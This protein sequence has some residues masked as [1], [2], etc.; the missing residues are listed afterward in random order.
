LLPIAELAKLLGS[1]PSS[2]KL[3]IAVLSARSASS[4]L[5]CI[6]LSDEI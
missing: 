3:R 5:V 2:Q 4:F 6:L 1:H